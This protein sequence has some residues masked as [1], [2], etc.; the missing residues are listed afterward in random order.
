MQHDM[1]VIAHYRIGADVNGKYTGEQVKAIFHPLATVLV[2]FT[3]VV[4]TTADKR[5]PHAS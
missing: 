1:S 4:V 3:G 5:P 2:G